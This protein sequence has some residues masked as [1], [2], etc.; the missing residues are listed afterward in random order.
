MLSDFK[1]LT[2]LV[3]FGIG[4][5]FAANRMKAVPVELTYASPLEHLQKTARG[6][7]IPA[8]APPVEVVGIDKV[9]AAVESRS[10]LIVDARPGI[11]WEM[12]HIPGAISLPRKTFLESYPATEPV[13]REAVA[14]GRPLLVYCADTHCPDAGAL[15]QELNQRGFKGIQLFE[16]GWAA[17]EEAGRT[18]E[19]K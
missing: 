4:L 9:A 7:G 3:L 19:A 8:D 16:A 14:A 15:A 12:G 6:P 17:W 2:L 5:A 1:L 11:F 18:V 10:C 13:L